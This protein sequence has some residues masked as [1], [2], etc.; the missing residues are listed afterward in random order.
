MND[1]ALRNIVVGLGAKAD[2]VVRE[3]R[4]SSSQ[5]PLRSWPSSAWPTD[6]DDLKERLGRIV[7]AY[8]FAGE[9]VTAEDLHAVGSMAAPAER[10]P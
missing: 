10:T 9:P 7:V 5:W 4:L 3:D 8:N 2:G 6:M 1:R